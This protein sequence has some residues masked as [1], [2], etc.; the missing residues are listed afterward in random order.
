MAMIEQAGAK[1]ADPFRRA[2]IVMQGDGTA[3]RAVAHAA[4]KLG[5][6]QSVFSAA[7]LQEEA[8]RIGL[9]K[10]GYAQIGATIETATKQGELIDRTF[11]D[12]PPE[13]I[14][15]LV[16]AEELLVSS[17]P[18]KTEAALANSVRHHRGICPRTGRAA[19]L[20]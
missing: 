2:D 1:A 8:G 5:E 11:Q 15:T 3:A 10:I 18:T 14:S 20:W 6:R 4:D 13:N 12:A 7:A 17:W 19:M 16:T 9:G